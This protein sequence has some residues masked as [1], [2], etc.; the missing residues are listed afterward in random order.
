MVKIRKA[1]R[2]ENIGDKTFL[3]SC[4][5]HFKNSLPNA[6]ENPCA[7]LLR[8]LCFLLFKILIDEGWRGGRGMERRCD[9]RKLEYVTR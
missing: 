4:L 8:S 9:D 5:P 3:I 2:E 6:V 7:K 1:G